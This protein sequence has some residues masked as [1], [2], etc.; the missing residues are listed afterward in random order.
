MQGCI[1]GLWA[2]N[3]NGAVQS[4]CVKK[5]TVVSLKRVKEKVGVSAVEE[6]PLLEQPAVTNQDL[7][8]ALLSDQ[9]NMYL[10]SVFYFQGFIY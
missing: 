7:Y 10:R 8:L 9:S 3:T 6:A 2:V 5:V 4:D 1:R